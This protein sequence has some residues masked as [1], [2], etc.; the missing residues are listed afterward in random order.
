[1]FIGAM[2]IGHVAR[3][4]GP[5]K[6]GEMPHTT[7]EAFPDFDGAD[8][9]PLTVLAIGRPCL[10]RARAHPRLYLESPAAGILRKENAVERQIRH[11]HTGKILASYS[12]VRTS[13]IYPRLTA[14]IEIEVLPGP[15]AWRLKA[16]ARDGHQESLGGCFEFSTYGE[17][18]VYVRAWIWYAS[19]WIGP[20]WLQAEAAVPPR[21]RTETIVAQSVLPRRRF[22]AAN[23][24]LLCE[25][26][27]A[28]SA[29]RL[30]RLLIGE[31]TIEEGG[32][33]EDSGADSPGA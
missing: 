28:Q 13:A 32:A 6:P 7:L 8:L 24:D 16:Q 17:I 3:N 25:P 4:R 5:H 20:S 2:P 11:K 12:D 9:P 1:M 19:N 10:E 33:A 14:A 27:D 29:D 18:L 30:F 26:L 23:T 21:G 15:S 22:A 31:E